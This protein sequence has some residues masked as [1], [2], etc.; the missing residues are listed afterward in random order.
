MA[1]GRRRARWRSLLVTVIALGIALIAAAVALTHA[2]SRSTAEGSVDA[3]DPA[4][5]ATVVRRDLVRQLRVPA[6]VGHEQARRLT[7]RRAG[8]ITWL[9]EPG[10]VV[11]RG[12]RV[13]EVDA[14]PVPLFLGAAPLYRP[15]SAGVPDGADVRLVQENLTALGFEAEPDGVF[16]P[17]T[18]AALTTWQKSIGVPPTGTMGPGDVVVAPGELRVASVTAALG[19][20][21]IGPV[22]T[23]TGTGR[24]AV[25]TIDPEDQA[26]LRPGTAVRFTGDVPPAAMT[27]TVTSVVPAPVGD[28]LG[29]STG[30]NAGQEYLVTIRFDD[31]QTA[32]TLLDGAAMTAMV[33]SERR[34]GVLAV[35]VA[36]LLALREGGY[37]VE[38]VDAGQRRLLAVDAG[39]FADGM[40]EVTG[41]GL[42]EGDTVVVAS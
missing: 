39:L 23:A 34:D 20:Q 2:V 32:A 33:E 27:G 31:Q 22:L 16:G 19:D 26:L 10:A 36:A 3:P 30:G 1:G 9:P 18:A 41:D 35:P 11:G 29:A 17:A 42:A 25:A 38:V 6:E 24:V 13:Y 40:V 4:Q 15:L 8:T 12:Q 7:G 5:T 37:A 28:D 14:V 21:G